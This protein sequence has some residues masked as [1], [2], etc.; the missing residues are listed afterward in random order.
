MQRRKPLHITIVG[1]YREAVLATHG[2]AERDE[3]VLD[4]PVEMLLGGQR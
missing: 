1:D 3:A 4:E 2:D